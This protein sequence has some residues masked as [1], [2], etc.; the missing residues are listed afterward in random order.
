MNNQQKKVLKKLINLC[1]KEFNYINYTQYIDEIIENNEYNIFDQIM[2]QKY[3]L[4]LYKM[5][6]GEMK[7]NSY[8]K[9]R[10]KLIDKERLSIN[11]FLLT[12]N[13][14]QVGQTIIQGTNSI[15]TIVKNEK[16][17]NPIYYW[18]NKILSERD[19]TTDQNTNLTIYD[20]NNK[21]IGWSNNNWIAFLSGTSSIRKVTYQ[22]SI[23][24]EYKYSLLLNNC[25]VYL[26]I[27]SSINTSIQN[28]IITNDISNNI[29]LGITISL[30]Y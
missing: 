8:N 9:I 30:N 19:G 7:L 29:S 10:S 22:Y 20:T 15:V 1:S 13:M 6:L 28:N 4:D 3:N 25:F 23:P 2:S 12:F 27:T 21:P 5:S 18:K 14:E 24:N 17:D 16:S 26:S 11:K